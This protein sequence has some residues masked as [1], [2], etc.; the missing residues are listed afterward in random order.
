MTTKSNNTENQEAS[1]SQDTPPPYERT[2]PSQ[3]D[4]ISNNPFY[5]PTPYE[6]VVTY[7]DNPK[8]PIASQTPQYFINSSLLYPLN[9]N[10]QYQSCNDYFLQA[11][12]RCGAGG[13]HEFDKEFTLGG[14][15]M[16]IFFFP[17]GILPCLCM[18]DNR[19]TKC[20][21]RFD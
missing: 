9:P 3:R 17:F 20:G 19:C 7:L 5:F 10:P 2:T 12:Q 21:G 18:T 4:Q 16:A 11:R 6:P 14:I 8:H 13:E 1:I 15:F